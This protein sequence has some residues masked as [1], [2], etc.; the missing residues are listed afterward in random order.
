MIT[1]AAQ[2][3]VFAGSSSNAPQAYAQQPPVYPQ[4]YQQPMLQGQVSF[5]PAGTPVAV[6]INEA[7]GSEIS[8]V[9]QTFNATL[10]GPIYAGNQLVAGPG[11]TV[12]G[13]IVSVEP[14]GRGGKAGSIDIRLTSV[15]T[16]D[17]RRYPLSAKVESNTFSLSADG[18]RLSTLA[19]GTAVGAG[20]GALSGL[21]GAAIGGGAK[22]KTT[23]IG[24]GIGGG[25]GLLGGAIKKGEEFIMKSGTQVPFVLDQPLQVNTAPQAQVQQYA[26]QGGYSPQG[27]S[28]PQGGFAE[29]S[30]QAA[31]QGGQYNPYL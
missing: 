27:Y 25:I 2:V 15:I 22:G 21:V 13:Q 9:G 4:G 28:A 8:S 11:S 12:Q 24:T 30:Q 23:A 5:V 17:G 10:S 29:P 18:G 1:I 3:P 26:P 7:L 19:K 31:P 20:A 14:A 6:I 16:P